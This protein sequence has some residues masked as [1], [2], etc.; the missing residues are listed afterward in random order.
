MTTIIDRLSIFFRL[1]RIGVRL[2][3]SY[4]LLLGIF[5]VVASISV[6]QIRKMADL[7]DKF[8]R[9]DMQR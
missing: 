9:N 2:A 3:L 4:A 6:A 7:S 1:R 5:V 8:A